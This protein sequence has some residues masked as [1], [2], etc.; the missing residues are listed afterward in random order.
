M[1][2]KISNLF[3]TRSNEV[4]VHI[5]DVHKTDEQLKGDYGVLYGIK[6]N[7][8]KNQKEFFATLKSA[9]LKGYITNFEI[10]DKCQIDWFEIRDDCAIDHFDIINF[11]NVNQSFLEELN[12][13][14]QLFKK[15]RCGCQNKAL[16]NR[17]KY[18]QENDIFAKSYE[19]MESWY[20]DKT[21]KEATPLE[22]RNKIGKTV[23]RFKHLFTRAS[24]PSPKKLAKRRK[25]YAIGRILSLLFYSLLGYAMFISGMPMLTIAFLA[26]TAITQ[27]LSIDIEK[28]L[29]KES[30]IAATESFIDHFANGEEVEQS[31]SLPSFVDFVDRD[32]NYLKN[33]TKNRKLQDDLESLARDYSRIKHDQ[34]KRTVDGATIPLN[35]AIT[36]KYDFMAKLLNYEI[37]MYSQNRRFGTTDQETV[38]ATEDYFFAMMNFIGWTSSK[39][40]KYPF[41]NRLFEEARRVAKMYYE[42]YEIEIRELFKLALKYARHVDT[43]DI[44]LE[45]FAASLK[46]I[47]KDIVAAAEYKKN[48][49]IKLEVLADLVIAQEKRKE[50]KRYAEIQKIFAADKDKKK[51]FKPVN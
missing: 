40:L 24:F 45:E 47:Q 35:E 5:L 14:E 25:K 10:G 1:E 30:V 41:L 51:N 26:C 36:Y 20:K 4:Y 19:A 2:Y 9:I 32:I 34:F 13:C 48:E 27:K 28:E 6:T 11:S 33:N 23:K 50:E 21:L 37:E 44:N 31:E 15:N 17:L 7:E 46:D 18:S 16:R 38:K 49:A 8:L 12:C 43:D 42:G 29:V 39:I 3:P 22:E